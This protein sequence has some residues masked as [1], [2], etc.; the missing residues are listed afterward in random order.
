MDNIHFENST[1]ALK[2]FNTGDVMKII[3][4]WLS[5]WPLPAGSKVPIMFTNVFLIVMELGMIFITT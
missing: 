1:A 3:N 5:A 4:T 2:P